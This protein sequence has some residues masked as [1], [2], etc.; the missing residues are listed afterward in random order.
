MAVRDGTVLGVNVV[1]PA[2][3]GRFPALMSADR[4]HIIKMLSEAVDEAAPRVA[5]YLRD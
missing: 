1:V 3:G 4:F 2:G 5:G